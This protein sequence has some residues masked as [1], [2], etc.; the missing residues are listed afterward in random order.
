MEIRHKHL[1]DMIIIA[2]GDDYLCTTMKHL[3]S[4]I[5]HPIVKC[6]QSLNTIHY[7]FFAIH[8]I[9]FPLQHVELLLAKVRRPHHLQS[10]IIE[11]LKGSDTGR[12][13]CN[14]TAIMSN[15]FLNSLPAYTDI[16]GM[17]LVTFNLFTLYRLESTGTHVKSQFLPF[18]PM[19]VK[20][21]QHLRREMQSCCWSGN[22]TLDL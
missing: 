2:G 13:H 6:L 15:Q 18:Y 20:I 12:T 1:D 4:S 7:S 17:H 5:T 3:K 9:W 10:H 19:G 14:G 16:L 8:V 22:T 21:R 11:T